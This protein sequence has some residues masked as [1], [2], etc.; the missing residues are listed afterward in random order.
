MTPVP[1]S[2]EIPKFYPV[3]PERVFAAWASEAA[4]SAWSAPPA[5]WT[6]RCEAFALQV[7]HSD[8]WQF[9]MIGETPYINRN[10]YSVIEP[11]RR[12]AYTTTLAHGDRVEF[13]GAV[14]VT[15]EPAPGGCRL[16]L[17]ET[18]IH[19]V[20]DDREGHIDGW[21]AMLD[22]LGEYLSVAAAA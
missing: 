9:G 18:G 6:M 7:G 1:A 14:C 2:I 4:M 5:G 10:Q 22:A 15:F 21:N 12:I 19:L 11:G 3:G 8:E 13:A 20:R 16:T 17:T